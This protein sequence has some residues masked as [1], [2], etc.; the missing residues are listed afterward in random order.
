MKPQLQ[1]ISIV[2]LPFGGEIYPC[3]A[4]TSV[5]LLAGELALSIQGDSGAET[6]THKRRDARDVRRNAIA[7][8]RAF[9]IHHGH[10]MEKLHLH[11]CDFYNP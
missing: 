1:M 7:N 5:I 4:S 9:A 11:Y 2:P 3:L 8:Y 10:Y 6:R